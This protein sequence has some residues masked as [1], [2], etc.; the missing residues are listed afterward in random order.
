MGG[1]RGT[2]LGVI[3]IYYKISAGLMIHMMIHSGYCCP[4]DVKE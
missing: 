4:H 1:Y 2:Y 3:L